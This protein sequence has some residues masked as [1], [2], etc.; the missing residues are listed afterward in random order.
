MLSM[1]IFFINS[2]P[3]PVKLVW[4]ISKHD[5]I[6]CMLVNK[7]LEHLFPVVWISWYFYTY[8]HLKF[9]T[10]MSWAWKQSYNLGAW[11]SKV[12]MTDQL[13]ETLKHSMTNN[14]SSKTMCLIEDN[15]LVISVKDF[16]LNLYHNQFFHLQSVATSSWH[17]NKI[18]NLLAQTKVC[19]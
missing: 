4:R 17:S 6:S 19:K 1:K 7:P 16:S 11:T 5:V 13:F 12:S 10:Q 15:P 3:G 18:N 2:G 8:E 14:H 9:H